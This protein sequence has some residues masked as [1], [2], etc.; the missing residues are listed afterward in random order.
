[1]AVKQLYDQLLQLQADKFYSIEAQFCTELYY[2]I[3]ADKR[4]VCVTVFLTIANWSATSMQSGVW[5]FY[6]ACPPDEVRVTL[7]YLQQSDTEELARM[8]AL[9]IHD[10]QNPK[11]AENFDYPQE[12]MD[13]AEQIDAWIMK[14]E[15]W[16]NEWK[17]QLLLKHREEIC[18][19][20]MLFPSQ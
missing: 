11:Y 1:M 6:E 14:H 18:S 13:E 10:Y 12:W 3:P 20:E 4:P 8:F 2:G 16:L 19:C 15:G 9:G 5:T 17:K 7:E